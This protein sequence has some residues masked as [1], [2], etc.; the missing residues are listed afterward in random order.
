MQSLSRI[1]PSGSLGQHALCHVALDYK[2]GRENVLMVMAVLVKT[3]RSE[4]AISAPAQLL[5]RFA[6]RAVMGQLLRICDTA[7]LY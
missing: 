6:Q 3:K 4:T 5:V 1:G 2:W 7:L